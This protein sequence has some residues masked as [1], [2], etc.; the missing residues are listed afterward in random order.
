M[1][2][3]KSSFVLIKPSRSDGYTTRRRREREATNQKPNHGEAFDKRIHTVPFGAVFHFL[4]VYD[5][6]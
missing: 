5:T 1:G 3:G 4:V 2:E 6:E